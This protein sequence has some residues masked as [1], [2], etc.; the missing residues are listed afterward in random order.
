MNQHAQIKTEGNHDN[1]GTVS[2]V[3]N[4]KSSPNSSI[5][6]SISQWNARSVHSL[7]KINYLRTLST[8]IIAIQEIWQRQYNLLQIGKGIDITDRAYKRGGG[9][10]S[11]CK[12]TL[13]LQILNKLPI[14][15]DTS[16]IKVRIQNQ[17]LWLINT[18]NYKGTTNKIQR[19]FGKIRKFIP[20]N[21]WKILCIIGDFNVDINKMTFESKLIKSLSKQMGLIIHTPSENTRGSATLDFLITGAKFA[22]ENHRVVPSPSDHNAVIWKL[23][24]YSAEAANP[25]KIP[26]RAL[27]DDLMELLL[28][29]KQVIDVKTFLE[30]LSILRSINNNDI[31]KTIKPKQQKNMEL[32]DKLLK[33]QDP[34]LIAETINKHWTRIWLHT[35]AQRYSRQSGTAYKQLKTI[36]K[37]HMFQKRDGGIISSILKEDGSITDR[38]DEIESLLFQTMEEIQVDHQWEWL[39]RKEFPKLKRISQEDMEDMLRTLATNKAIAFDATSGLLFEDYT[40]YDEEGKTNLQKTAKKFRNIWRTNMD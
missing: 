8:D 26:N 10:A 24:I 22:Q 17:Y 4:F 39:E 33:I 12:A 16:A 25:L 3:S 15:K 18:Y 6:I 23:K 20:M 32:F 1:M 21:E 38:Q 19:L 2:G 36:L 34:N 13:N 30:K 28:S 37:Y 40:S 5:S 14:N 31:M 29:N 35:E 27:A 9:T 7:D 11:I